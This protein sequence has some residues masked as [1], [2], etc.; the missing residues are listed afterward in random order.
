MPSI[1]LPINCRGIYKARGYLHV[2]SPDAPD[3]LPA[4]V[5]PGVLADGDPKDGNLDPSGGPSRGSASH[6]QVPAP[7]GHMTELLVLCTGNA[8]RSVMA[9]FMLDHLKVGR[10]VA[11]LHVVTAGTHSIDGQPMSTRTR[12]ALRSIPELSDAAL[13]GH[14]SRQ[15]YEGD[16][17]RAELVVVM[18]AD[19]VRFVR[20]QFPRAAGR[21]ATIRRLCR[22]LPPGPPPLDRAG[23]R[24]RSGRSASPSGRTTSSTRPG[25]TRPP[26]WPAPPNC[27]CSARG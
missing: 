11:D 23:G 16:L 5:G 20:R 15:V 9:G 17:D 12:A 10:P 27:G 14:R 18:E 6:E 26:T 13:G 7:E 8:A 2:R 25:A 1:P 4:R 19:H 22:D 3:L 24:P 21:T